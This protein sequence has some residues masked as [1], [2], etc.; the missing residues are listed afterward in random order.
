MKVVM[1]Y[2]LNGKGEEKF[3]NK[4]QR[5]TFKQ[6]GYLIREKWILCP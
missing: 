2:V 4:N 3:I 6:L 1:Y 5:R